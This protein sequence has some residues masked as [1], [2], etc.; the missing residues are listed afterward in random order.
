MFETYKKRF[1][2]ETHLN[3]LGDLT[4][5]EI[6]ENTYYLVDFLNSEVQ[7]YNL[8]WTF[9]KIQ[10]LPISASYDLIHVDKH[11]FVMSQK[12]FY[13]MDT[14]FNLVAKSSVH[15]ILGLTY[16]HMYY[17]NLSSNFYTTLPGSKSI[18]VFNKNLSIIK[19]IVTNHL[20]YSINGYKGT[21]FASTLLNNKILLIQNDQ[22]VK[23]II[24]N[25]C[26]SSPYIKFSFDSF[27]NI[28]VICNFKLNLY[29]YFGNYVKSYPSFDVLN[30]IFYRSDSEG[31]LISVGKTIEIYY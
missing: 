15:T 2:L 6:V 26:E 25:Q 12:Y 17:D 13:K 1:S 21:I 24:F 27:G 14:D 18:E 22:V 19:T 5:F 11:L 30:K 4:A 9:K 23:S 3:R 16:R 7:V 20:L 28:A 10:K 8:D 31:R 29:D